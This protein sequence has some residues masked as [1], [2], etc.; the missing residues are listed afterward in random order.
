MNPSKTFPESEALADHANAFLSALQ[1]LDKGAFPAEAGEALAEVIKAVRETAQK[2]S[3]TIKL[4]IVPVPKTE[5]AQVTITPALAAKTPKL[6][7]KAR[8]FYTD[9]DGQLHRSDPNQQEF[10]F[11]IRA[12]KPKAETAKPATEKKA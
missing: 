11:T 3:I 1:L 2:G 6:S 9:G 4:E 10:G 12:P 5:G 7:P 8:T